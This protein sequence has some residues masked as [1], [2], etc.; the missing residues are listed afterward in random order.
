MMDEYGTTTL[1][2]EERAKWQRAARMLVESHPK[3]AA[4]LQAMSE[5]GYLH[6]DEY[7]TARDA[8]SRWAF[9]L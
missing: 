1:S 3:L 8:I 7:A 4:L 9:P 5:R 2:D 6:V